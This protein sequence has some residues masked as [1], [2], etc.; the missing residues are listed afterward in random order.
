MRCF[1]VFGGCRVVGGF[2]MIE[3]LV[4]IIVLVFGLFGFVLL[5]IMNVCFVQSVNY[6]I[7]VMNLV[8]D[9]IDQMWVN[10]FQLVWYMGV[11]FVFGMVICVV[12]MCLIGIVIIGQNVVCW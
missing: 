1:C 2:S 3:V 9:L 11:L 6:C 8:Y 5:Q 4:I 7:Q 10:W 12:C